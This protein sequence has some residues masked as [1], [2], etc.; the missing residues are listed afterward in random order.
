MTRDDDDD[1]DDDD[2]CTM[3]ETTVVVCATTI[4]FSSP[5]CPLA[6]A[7]MTSISKCL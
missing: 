3:M 4:P 5:S 2:V 7:L 1:D 6:T